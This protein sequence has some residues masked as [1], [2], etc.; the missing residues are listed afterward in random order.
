M[1]KSKKLIYA[2]LI[3]KV[4]IFGFAIGMSACLILFIVTSIWIGRGVQ[5]SCQLAQKKYNGDC[6]QALILYLQDES[7]PYG[8]RNSAIW[9][10][11]QL[12]DSRAL[13]VLQSY[14][15]GNI[16][17]KEPWNQTLSQYELKKA[18]NLI[19]GGYNITAFIWRSGGVINK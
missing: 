2:E 19:Q 11:G 1:E 6:V 10:L 18:I 7:H 4:V 5:K 3:K 8:E 12:G 15:T 16:P 9:A 13:P 17:D 14:F